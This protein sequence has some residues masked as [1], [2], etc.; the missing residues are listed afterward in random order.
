MGAGLELWGR[1]RDGSHVPVEIAL[2]PVRS[3]DTL[4]TVAVI[5]DVTERN[6]AQHQL[7]ASAS[8]VA[9]LEER[10]RIARDLHDRVIQR[11][12]AAGLAL[13]A[14]ATSTDDD[15]LVSRLERVV[16]DV[17]ESIRDLRTVIFGLAR[18][19]SRKSLRDEM[20]AIATEARRSLSYEPRV[21][22]R[23]AVDAIVPEPSWEHITSA[24]RE[25]L[26]NVARHAHATHVDI[27][28]EVG[29][30]FALCVRDDGVGMPAA[31]S[32]NGEGLRNLEQRAAA[33]GGRFDI[34]P[35]RPNGTVARWE[36]PLR[37]RPAESRRDG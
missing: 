24:L 23:G 17:D 14:I 36:I 33:L 35:A 22:F 26:S 16:D 5:R 21:R 30:T 10:E 34:T 1:R 2:S 19:A 28:V 13:Q 6:E 8:Q 25:M 3:S 4:F 15:A 31:P 12:F 9:L 29:D 11:L 20:L 18:R 32:G 37:N 7:L 27:D